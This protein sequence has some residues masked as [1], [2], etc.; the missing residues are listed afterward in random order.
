MS[1]RRK[2]AGDVKS[3]AADAESIVD[4]HGPVERYE[5]HRE[6]RDIVLRLGDTVLYAHRKMSQDP[7]VPDSFLLPMIV[8][9]IFD[10]QA[11]NGVVF[12]DNHSTV[13]FEGCKVVREVQHGDGEGQ[14]QYQP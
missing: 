11:V 6:G 13:G 5:D 4:K 9:K 1:A 8:T 14:W 12:S 2:S 10:G 3:P 7:N